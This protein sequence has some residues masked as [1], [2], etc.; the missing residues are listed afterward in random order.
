MRSYEAKVLNIIM[1]A[2]ARF[3]SKFAAQASKGGRIL[4]T[5][6][7]IRIAAAKNLAEAKE[8]LRQAEAALVEFQASPGMTVEPKKFGELVVEIERA[9][10][11]AAEAEAAL[12]AAKELEEAVKTGNSIYRLG[13]PGGGINNIDEQQHAVP[14][15]N[16]LAAGTYE[17]VSLDGIGLGALATLAIHYGSD[18]VHSVKEANNQIK[19]LEEPIKKFN[20]AMQKA[21]DVETARLSGS[22]WDRVTIPSEPSVVA[23]GP[24]P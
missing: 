5:P 11:L 18:A 10:A 16:D 8:A 22:V 6:A 13:G 14:G 4:L 19:E 7:E 17:Q 9:D 15:N 3:L 1:N 21:D 12:T 24:K 2:L 20:E 23:S